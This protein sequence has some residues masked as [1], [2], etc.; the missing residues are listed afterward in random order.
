MQ[1]PALLRRGDRDF[2]AAAMFKRGNTCT[3]TRDF[4]DV[5]L[6]DH[7]LRVRTAFGEHLAPR[8]DNHTMSEGL[9]LVFVTASLRGGE[10]ERTRFDRA[11]ALQHMPVRLAGLL[12]ESR[13]HGEEMRASAHKR[14]VKRWEAQIIADRKAEPS[15]RQVGGYCNFAGPVGIR[16]A[17]AL[18]ACE[19]NIEKMNLVVAR[20]DLAVRR[21]QEAAVGGLVVGNLD[22]ERADVKVGLQI[23]RELA[24]RCG[25]VITLL[26]AKLR[27]KAVAALLHDAR[28]LGRLDVIGAERLR[29]ADQLACVLDIF[30]DGQGSAH[31]H[32]RRL[33]FRLCSGQRNLLPVK[34]HNTAVQT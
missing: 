7:D 19:L 12:G 16:L 3:H 11:R 31:L 6:G 22:R 27:E 28:H 15:P 8:I 33:E 29:L 17:I 13:G 14:T 24:A 34:R 18:A 9:A 2:K 1:M 21:N 4:F 25:R 10:H 5:D 32:H 20:G 26:L 30:F 23:A